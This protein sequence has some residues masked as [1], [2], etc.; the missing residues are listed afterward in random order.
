[1]KQLPRNGWQYR[2][3]K[4]QTKDV[5]S[6]IQ[7]FEEAFN[8]L[9]GLR[10]AVSKMSDT[11]F[12]AQKEKMEKDMCANKEQNTYEL[13]QVQLALADQNQTA[14]D[15]QEVS[16]LR[17]LGYARDNEAAQQQ[18]RVRQEVNQQVADQVRF[19]ELEFQKN[20]A[21]LSARLSAT[22]AE[23]KALH[24]EIASLRND[25][26]AQKKLSRDIA[27]AKGSGL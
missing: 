9:P 23:R 13:K 8:T 3:L 1:M 5:A 21:E 20:Y 12:S 11:I 15:A 25:V 22:D 26:T 14:L 10:D 7:Q 4:E 17:N 24:D 27:T 18:N 19:T 2:R 16:T 6:K